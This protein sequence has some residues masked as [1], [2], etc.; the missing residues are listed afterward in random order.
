MRCPPVRQGTSG[1]ATVGAERSG[2]VGAERLVEAAQGWVCVSRG[3]VAY[4]LC[5]LEP[6]G[7]DHI[8]GIPI[9][10]TA[11][12]GASG[13]GESTCHPQQPSGKEVGIIQKQSVRQEIQRRKRQNHHRPRNQQLFLFAANSAEVSRRVQNR[14]Q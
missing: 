3:T 13:H 4:G 11:G 1:A 5:P 14:Q 6:A 2:D 7:L 9:P 12:N 8:A 10:C